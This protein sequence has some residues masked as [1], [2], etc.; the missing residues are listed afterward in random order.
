MTVAGPEPLLGGLAM[1]A[2][3]SDITILV[4]PMPTISDA[5]Y[6]GLLDEVS[7]LSQ[8]AP[9]PP[10]SSVAFY[11]F[12]FSAT[13]RRFAAERADDHTRRG[14]HT[15]LTDSGFLRAAIRAVMWLAPELNIL[16]YAPHDW[17]SASRFLSEVSP[18]DED[19]LGRVLPASFESLG[20]D[21]PGRPRIGL[22]PGAA[23]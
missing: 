3:V 5:Q 17:R 20:L 23:R 10:R 19:E 21:L 1:W 18:H 11:G 9:E 13:Q 12:Q 6:S 7:A 14:R 16:A 4:V 15:I 2:Q 22:G 8:R